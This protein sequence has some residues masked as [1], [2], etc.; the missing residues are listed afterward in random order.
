MSESRL[1]THKQ[2]FLNIEGIHM[3]DTYA[4]GANALP[5]LINHYQ[6]KQNIKIYLNGTYYLSAED[7]AIL[8]ELKDE[9][10]VKINVYNSNK[11]YITYFKDFW[12]EPGY[13][14]SGKK[15]AFHIGS[16]YSSSFMDEYNYILS[17]ITF[18]LNSEKLI[19]SEIRATDIRQLKAFIIRSPQLKE[20]ID[21]YISRCINVLE[22]DRD[23][24][25]IDS[26]ACI[27]EIKSIQENLQADEM[28]GYVFTQK[29]IIKATH[30]EVFLIKK[31]AIIKPLHWGDGACSDDLHKKL[32]EEKFTLYVSSVDD[33]ALDESKSSVVTCPQ[34]DRRSCATLGMLYLKELLKDNA[35]QSQL[36]LCFSYNR[37][38]GDYFRKTD[39]FVPSPQVL[40][41]SQS[42]LYN[43]IVAAA[44]TDSIDDI[45]VDHHRTPCSVTTF[46]KLLNNSIDDTHLSVEAKKHNQSILENYHE[47]SKAWLQEYAQIKDKRNLMQVPLCNVYLSYRTHGF[48]NKTQ[49]LLTSHSSHETATVS[50]SKQI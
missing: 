29:N 48:W 21:S 12:T 35:K 23:N 26:N 7:Q 11:K 19:K 15:E 17:N 31:N 14:L 34:A 5:F 28:V 18:L 30:F 6:K 41:Y 13:F 1:S 20:K 3:A 36:S 32:L 22:Q 44:M 24:L 10:Q 8:Q 43:E 27:K 50:Q 45:A 16:T 42:E 39:I 47:F 49:S 4:L 38:V 40:R 33:I 25:W 2:E 9:I 46:K 37:I